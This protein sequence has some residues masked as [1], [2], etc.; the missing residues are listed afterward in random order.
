MAP[1]CVF[2]PVEVSA[3]ARRDG[4]SARELWSFARGAA[5]QLRDTPCD[6][7]HT[8]A[9]STWVSDVL[10]LPGIVRGE[11]EMAGI[12]RARGFASRLRH[13]GNYA[14]LALER[15]AIRNPRVSRYH[16][17]A[18]IVKEHLRRFYGV[19]DDAV[20]VITPGVNVDEFHPSDR[21]EARRALALPDDGRPLVLFCGHDFARKGLDRAIRALP[22]MRERAELVVVGD[23]CEQARF[24]RLAVEEGVGDRVRF[25]GRRI[26]MS[27]AYR[28]ADVF[29]LPTRSDMWGATVLEAM[30]SGLPVVVT[31]S[32]G[33]ASVVDH[34]RSGFVLPSEPTVDQLGAMLDRLLGDPPLRLALARAGHEQALEHTW[35]G[36]GARV[37]RDL[38]AIAAM[39]GRTRVPPSTVRPR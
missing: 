17:D 11:L 30:A 36:V 24:H 4:F 15:R 20:S 26:D 23:S 6:V 9:P 10:H 2:H 16:V 31:E 39:R 14:R 22:V 18:P 3:I 8:R 1:G 7:V 19:H 25:L 35:E 33:V 13:P 37:E 5:V 27:V 28:A 34:G 12:S 38:V 29:V 21:V 32:A